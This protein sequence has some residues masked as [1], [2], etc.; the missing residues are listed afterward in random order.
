[1]LSIHFCPQSSLCNTAIDNPNHLVKFDAV[2]EILSFLE[3]DTILF[4]SA[5]VDNPVSFPLSVVWS[6]QLCVF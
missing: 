2:Q 3:T 6:S 1:M 4:E 5:D